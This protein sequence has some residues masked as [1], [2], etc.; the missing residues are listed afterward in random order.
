MNARQKKKHFKSKIIN[1]K[2]GEILFVIPDTESPDFNIN[3]VCDFCNTV[4]KH[5]LPEECGICM[6]PF[7]RDFKVYDKE[8]ALKYLDNLKEYIEEI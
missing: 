8:L 2:P 6:L 5:F 3:I 1:M 4:Q 7:G